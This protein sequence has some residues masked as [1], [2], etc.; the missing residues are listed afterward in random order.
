MLDTVKQKAVSTK[1]FVAKH[2]VAITVVTTSSFWL[3]WM[4]T[5]AKQHNDFLKEHDLYD[6]FYKSFEDDE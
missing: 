2:K 5:V 3:W 4:M 6:E 1:K